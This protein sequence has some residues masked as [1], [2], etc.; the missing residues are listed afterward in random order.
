MKTLA[1]THLFHCILIAALARPSL[2]MDE[3]LGFLPHV[4]DLFHL[5]VM[6]TIT[7]II[8]GDD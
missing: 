4:F 5:D 8:K 1:T 6:I 7:I 3:I 2:A